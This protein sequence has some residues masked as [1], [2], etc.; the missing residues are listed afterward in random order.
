MCFRRC[1]TYECTITQL[2][3][4]WYIIYSLPLLQRSWSHCTPD[5]C[6]RNSP[7]IGDHLQIDTLTSDV[8]RWQFF[9]AWDTEWNVRLA[10][11]NFPP[12]RCRKN[13]VNG[14]WKWS[15]QSGFWNDTKFYNFLEWICLA[16]LPDLST[17]DPWL[18]SGLLTC[19]KLHA[20]ETKACTMYDCLQVNNLLEV[21]LLCTLRVW[22]D[23]FSSKSVFYQRSS[24][25]YTKL[26][27]FTSVML[28]QYK[29]PSI[30]TQLHGTY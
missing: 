22:K 2:Y 13:V 6:Y 23:R 1:P 3:M 8:S 17:N 30:Q 29:W 14:S 5:P 26:P 7:F 4:Y 18:F 21:N 20:L 24:R 15:R 27:G 28:K 12:C 25:I 9:H 16:A 10:W 19:L 11:S